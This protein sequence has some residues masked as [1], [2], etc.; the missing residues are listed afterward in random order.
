MQRALLGILLVVVAVTVFHFVTRPASNGTVVQEPLAETLERPAVMSDDSVTGDTSSASATIAETA[1]STESSASVESSVPRMSQRESDFLTAQINRQIEEIKAE[2][3]D[4]EWAPDA[5]EI[6]RSGIEEYLQAQPELRQEYAL[7]SVDCRT[8]ACEISIQGFG[9]QP[10]PSSPEDIALRNMINAVYVDLWVEDFQ[11]DYFGEVLT[12]NGVY[13]YRQYFRRRT[14]P[15]NEEALRF[16]RMP[17]LGP[18]P[19]QTE[20]E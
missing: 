15:V 11:E 16:L 18:R 12:G 1:S 13:E 19:V 6:L 8:S 20:G 9:P 10:R 5:G 7:I 14:S 17:I 2:L 4:P 3:V